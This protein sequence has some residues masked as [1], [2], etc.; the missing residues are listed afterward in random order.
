MSKLSR[1]F[2]LLAGISLICFGVSRFL[3]GVWVPFLWIPLGLSIFFFAGIFWLDRKLLMEFLS[4]KTTK[5]GLSMG[6][7]VLLVLIFL[8]AIN[9]ISVRKYK[10]WDF[11]S[12]QVN[13]LSE[14]S[15]TLLK[16]LSEELKVYYF[17]KE[18]ER[19]VE[20]NKRA[21]IELLKKYQDQS[22]LVRLDFIEV[23]RNPELTK[24]FEV[25]KGSGLVFLEYKNKRTR[26]DRI[27][28]QEVSSG[29]MKVMQEKN[30]VIYMLV[31]HGEF[32][33]ASNETSGAEQMARLLQGINYEIK[34]LSMLTA[35]KVPDDADLLMIVGA[36]QPF[37]PKEI[38]MLE[39]YMTRGGS[40][41]VALDSQK[42][43]QLD[44]FLTKAG[45][46]LNNDLVIQ[47]IPT[48][49]GVEVVPGPTPVNVFSST[50]VI[51]KPFSPRDM[52]IMRLPTSLQ[53]SKSNP[54]IT[55][56]EFLKAQ[57]NAF[58]F[59][60]YQ[61]KNLAGQAP[62]T[63]GVLSKGKW[64]GSQSG[65]EFQIVLFGDADFLGNQMIYQYVNRDL[66]FNS[67]ASLVRDETVISISP[68]E[69]G[70]TKM[71]LSDEQFMAL[72]LGFVLPLLAIFITT[73][74]T[75]WYRR[76]YA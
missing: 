15:K 47:G 30:K 44:G 65:K 10:T 68:K 25:N 20:E 49:Q 53:A 55:V 1:L 27:E 11:S 29:L 40:L 42:N 16:N 36:E 72:I 17:Y 48:S 60:D 59:K 9:F 41:L 22:S 12:A 52:V 28:E 34:P 26:L 54:E 31:G 24:K 39:E 66:L 7:L 71:L 18:G 45:L 38:Q 61:F 13:T 62:F 35:P 14:Q 57:V 4:V 58:A 8:I 32:D 33:L 73:S 70:I 76:R 46:K 69:I 5:Q 67:V 56:D 2:L 3:F 21:F 75:I 6:S 37:L 50:Q 23:N 19:G 74:A 51:T 63:L 43:H 64:P